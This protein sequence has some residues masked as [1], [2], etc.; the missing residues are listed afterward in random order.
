MK[1]FRNV[2]PAC[3][4]LW[5]N[6]A[7]VPYV[8]EMSPGAALFE[9][10]TCAPNVSTALLEARKGEEN[11]AMYIALYSAVRCLGPAPKA[12]ARKQL[13]I[14]VYPPKRSV[15]MFGSPPGFEARR[16]RWRRRWRRRYFDFLDIVAAITPRFKSDAHCLH[17]TE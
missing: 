3:P 17:P 7:L 6:P 2:R 8:F 9:E 10:R 12:S 16:V 5:M 11:G 14:E 4:L 1:P 15:Y 13:I